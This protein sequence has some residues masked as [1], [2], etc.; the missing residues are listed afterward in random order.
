MESPHLTDS[1][2]V[3]VPEDAHLEVEEVLVTCGDQEEATEEGAT[4]ILHTSSFCLVIG[5]TFCCFFY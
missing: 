2:G 4:I 1:P 3:E 5:E